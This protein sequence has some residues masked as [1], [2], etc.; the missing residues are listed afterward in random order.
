LIKSRRAASFYLRPWL[1]SRKRKRRKADDDKPQKIPLV[2]SPDET[3]CLLAVASK[4]S[5]ALEADGR[6]LRAGWQQV[7]VA[8]VARLSKILDNGVH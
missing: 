4:Y 2:M 8:L 5:E 7:R 6:C 3:R 1:E